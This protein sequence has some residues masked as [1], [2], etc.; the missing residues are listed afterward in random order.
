MGQNP[1]ATRLS[2]L[3]PFL[4]IFPQWLWVRNSNDDTSEGDREDAVKKAKEIR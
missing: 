1:S 2:K 4:T 3:A